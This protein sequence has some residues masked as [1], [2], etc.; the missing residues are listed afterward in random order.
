MI[1]LTDFTEGEI[2]RLYFSTIPSE[3]STVQAKIEGEAFYSSYVLKSPINGCVTNISAN[4]GQHTESL[5]NTIEI[6]DP[7]SFQLK[8][9]VFEK[10]ISNVKEDQI[11][12]FYLAGNRNEKFRSKI[13]SAGKTIHPDS[14]SVDCYANI[15]NGTNQSF[16][17]YQ[18]VEGDILVANDTVLALP[19]TAILNSAN[20]QYVLILEKEAGDLY[21]FKKT[22]VNTKRTSNELVEL[23]SVLP[24]G[25]LLVKGIYNIQAE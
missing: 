14:K 19:E 13:I 6:I 23:T 9:S 16:V 15:E 7:L 21:Y 3:P 25:R 11:V 1:P 22:E 20:K 8:L 12:E 24:V 2:Q 4:I 10:D 18:F 5:Q 17:S